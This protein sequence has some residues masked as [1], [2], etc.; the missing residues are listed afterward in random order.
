MRVP[1]DK[2]DTA[3][4]LEAYLQVEDGTLTRRQAAEKASKEL[5]QRAIDRGMEIDDQ[6]RN[7]AGIRKQLDVMEFN[8]TDGKRGYEKR[9]KIFIEVIDLYRSRREA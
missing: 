4:L 5:R 6:F 3:I 2:Y 9:T 7:Y 8:Y 1:F